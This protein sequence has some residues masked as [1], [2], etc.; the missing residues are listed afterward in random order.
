MQ[1][2]GDAAHV[3]CREIHLE[4]LGSV[5]NPPLEES[6]ARRRVKYVYIDKHEIPSGARAVSSAFE[7]KKFSTDDNRR[8]LGKLD[9]ISDFTD[10]CL[11]THCDWQWE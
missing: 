2:V 5:E 8:F 7:T 4:L 1:D 9:G 10:Q 11:E 3:G 6:M